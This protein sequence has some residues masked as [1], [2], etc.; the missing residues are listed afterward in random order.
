MTGDGYDWSSRVLALSISDSPDLDVLGLLPGED[1]RILTAVLTPLVY[2]KARLAYGGRIE[3]ASATNFTTEIGFQLAAAY[4]TSDGAP[5]ERPY[6]HYLRDNDARREG[7]EGLFGHAL[8]LGSFSEVRLLRGTE[9]CATLL[10]SGDLIDIYVD[11]RS[12]GVARDPDDLMKVDP[13]ARCFDGATGRDELADMRE[14]MASE[15]SARVIMGGRVSGGRGGTSGVAAEALTALRV[16]KPLL[17]LGGLGGASRDVAHVLGL[18][19][20][21]EAITRTEDAYKDADGH[22]SAD[23]YWAHMDEIAAFRD[24]YSE[25]MATRDLLTVARRLARSDSTEEIGALVF[26]M[27]ERLLFEKDQRPKT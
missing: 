25:A 10:P 20:A 26:Q 22:P 21:Q 14:A 27:V 15:T 8:R 19:D 9:A 24:D 17:V 11:G 12:A 3:P 16:G 18:I 5:G 7:V 2:Y 23:R 13:I 6:I 4:R 1:K